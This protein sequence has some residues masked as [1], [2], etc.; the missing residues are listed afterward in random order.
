MSSTI[1]SAIGQHAVD[2]VIGGMDKITPGLL[3]D[4]EK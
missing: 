3:A 1:T 2:H 4:L